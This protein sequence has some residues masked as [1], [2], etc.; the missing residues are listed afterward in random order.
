MSRRAATRLVLPGFPRAEP[1]TSA[2]QAREYA[3]ADRIQCLLCGK[4]YR[5]L[6]L[7]LIHTHGEDMDTYRQRFGIPYGVRL[8]GLATRAKQRVNL[9]NRL[10]RE[11]ILAIGDLGRAHTGPLEPR[12]IVS[13]V[14][15]QRCNRISMVNQ[16]EVVI[17]ACYRCGRDVETGQ[18]RRHRL[19]KECH[20]ADRYGPMTDASREKI[21]AWTAENEQRAREYN[22]AKAHWVRR[23]DPRPLVEYAKKWGAQ[24]RT[25][26]PA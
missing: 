3:A 9:E 15:D 12:P 16:A 18:M 4:L 5:A 25:I 7:H 24:L 6:T 13:T 11:E 17:V 14:L 22:R 20:H 23:R 19:C 1:F 8:V 26:R 21:R 2:A 10:T